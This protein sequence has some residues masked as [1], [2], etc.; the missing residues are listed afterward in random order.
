MAMIVSILARLLAASAY[1]KVTAVLLAGCVAGFVLGQ[2][3]HQPTPHTVTPAVSSPAR[4]VAAIAG[5]LGA[6]VVA[7]A[8]I[9]VP[10][11]LSHPSSANPSGD[12]DHQHG[13]DADT[14]HHGELRLIPPS[15]FG[16][17]RGHDGGD[18]GGGHGHH[19]GDTPSPTFTAYV[20]G[21]FLTFI[22]AG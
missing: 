21:S 9:T 10:L 4:S 22:L 20:G 6:P 14:H 18:G 13:P 3:A 17:G 16:H 11:S 15:W 2:A 7:P 8:H 19:D 5:S 1:R 12:D